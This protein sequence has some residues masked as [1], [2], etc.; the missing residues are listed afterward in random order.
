MSRKPA[1]VMAGRG[2]RCPYSDLFQGLSIS[3]RDAFRRS[4][5]C[6]VGNGRRDPA[7]ESNFRFLREPVP[8]RRKKSTAFSETTLSTHLTPTEFE[9]HCGNDKADRAAWS[10]RHAFGGQGCRSEIHCPCVRHVPD[11]LTPG[12]IRNGNAIL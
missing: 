11:E 9:R 8:G 6:K 4:G 1:V 2:R 12:T 3:W 7:R 5:P 10:P